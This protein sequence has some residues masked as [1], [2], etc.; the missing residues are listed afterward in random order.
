MAPKCP[1]TYLL[2]GCGQRHRMPVAALSIL[3]VLWRYS[4]PR[5]GGGWNA[6]LAAFFPSNS[7]VRP[8]MG[9][10]E[11]V[12]PAN[13]GGSSQISCTPGTSDI[14]L[15]KHNKDVCLHLN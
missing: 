2:G 12:L 8:A 10:L 6:G 3:H 5:L 14:M 4:K 13:S 1:N 9:T 7:L 15:A 11:P